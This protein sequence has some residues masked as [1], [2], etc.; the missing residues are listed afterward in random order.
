MVRG[1]WLAV[2]VLA[3]VGMVAACGRPAVDLSERPSA[4]PSSPDNAGGAAPLPVPRV[5]S[6]GVSR[7]ALP[8]VGACIDSDHRT[9]TCAEPHQGEVTLIGHLPDGLPSSPPDDTTMTKAALPPC[10]D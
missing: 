5:D 8:A 9:V 2:I 3:L 10:R 4:T 1:G 7:D 6:R